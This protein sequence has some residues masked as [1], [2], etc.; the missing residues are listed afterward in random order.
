[1]IRVLH[2]VNWF[3]AGGVET[4]L[5]EILRKYDRRR[6]HMDVCLIGE[7]PGPLAGDAEA[8]GAS[9]FSCPKSPD[10]WSFSRRFARLCHGRN[11][12]VVHSH[13]ET[14]SGA[15]LRGARAAGVP[16][17]IAHFH[18]NVPWPDEATD[19]WW[20]TAARALVLRWGRYWTCKH[21]TNV[22]AVSNAVMESRKLQCRIS[23]PEVGIWTGGV[24]TARFLPRSD[25]AI[26]STELPVVIWVGALRPVKRIDLQLHIFKAVLA[27]LPDAELWLAG[28]GHQEPALVAL[29]DRLGIISSVKFLGLRSD[30]PDLLRSASVF[31]SCSDAEGLPTVLLEA[32]AC[33]LPVVA[34]DIAPHREATSPDLHPFLFR[35]DSPDAAAESIVRILSDAGLRADLGRAGRAFI[36]RRYDADVK[37]G[38][39]L[40]W[41]TSWVERSQAGSSDRR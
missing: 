13:F 9:I 26:G 10:L 27:S 41:Y 22:L 29:A 35:H 25:A 34:T 11:Y 37:L 21:A 3:H 12:H 28:T 17:R 16:V 14:W 39:L 18:S 8:F 23:A 19:P 31:L 30:V 4:Q 38:V 2:V 15:I 33:G 7:E 1:M 24:D 20:L 40:N 36:Q 5:L 6:F 32:Q